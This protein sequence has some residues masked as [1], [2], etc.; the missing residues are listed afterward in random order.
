MG[1]LESP[2]PSFHLS[3]C[4]GIFIQM[5]CF[6]LL[7]G[8]HANFMRLIAVDSERMNETPIVQ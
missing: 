3:V 6:K 5:V 7:K 2:C 1:V 8:I 4:Q